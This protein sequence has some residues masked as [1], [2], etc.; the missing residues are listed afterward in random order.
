MPKPNLNEDLSNSDIFDG[1]NNLSLPGEGVNQEIAAEIK[2]IVD[3]NY[4]PKKSRPK[5]KSPETE[6]P[7]DVI[8]IPPLTKEPEPIDVSFR[9]EANSWKLL[10]KLSCWPLLFS[11]FLVLISFL[12]LALSLKIISVS[13]FSILLFDLLH[14]F[15]FLI[16]K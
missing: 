4:S 5:K 9:I 6:P 15:K 7:F 16:R 8:Q 13:I 14:S 12:P 1:D 10:I 3:E 2:N 11:A